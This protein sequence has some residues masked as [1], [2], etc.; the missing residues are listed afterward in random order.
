MFIQIVIFYFQIFKMEEHQ[1]VIW[2]S[3]TIK[4]RIEGKKNI[5]KNNKICYRLLLTSM[6]RANGK[7]AARLSPVHEKCA[8]MLDSKREGERGNESK[9]ERKRE[10]E[11]GREAGSV[12]T[13]LKGEMER[14]SW[15]W[16]VIYFRSRDIGPPAGYFSFFL[17]LAR[18]IRYLITSLFHE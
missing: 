2:E 4:T 12:K 5:L 14:A 13:W 7:L 1:K 15:G 6:K 10:G 9:R 11:R 17:F 18:R 8:R 3:T 16:A